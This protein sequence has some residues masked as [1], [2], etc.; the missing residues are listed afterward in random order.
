MSES[1]DEIIQAQQ[2]PLSH[3]S[4]ASSQRRLGNLLDWRSATV[5]VIVAVVLAS[6]LLW[7]PEL[8]APAAPSPASAETQS[9]TTNDPLSSNNTE[10]LAPFAEAQRQ[11]VREQAQEALAEFVEMQILLEDTMHVSEWGAAELAESLAIA[12]SGDTEFHAE[13]FEDSLNAYHNAANSLES[14]LARGNALFDQYVASGLEHI[15]SLDPDAATSALAEAQLIKP[16]DAALLAALQR[17][18]RLPQVIG[19]LRTAKNHELG[20]RYKK[21]LAQYAEIQQLDPLTAGLQQLKDAAARAQAGDDLTSHISRGFVALENREF[22]RAKQ[23]FNRA[24]ALDADNDIAKGGLQ[25][26]A[27]QN[28]L[29]II[30]RHKSAADSAMAAEDWQSAIDAFQAVLVL[31]AN[32]QFALNGLGAANAHQR[33]Q[34]LLDKISSEP[35]KL[36]S[37]KLYLDA[38]AIV[39]DAKK[40]EYAG[41]NLRGLVE[42]VDKLLLA[43]RD[44]V[45]VVLVSD[46]ATNV[47][48]SNVGQLGFFERKTLTLRPGQYTIRGSQDGCRDI[49]LLVEVLPGIAPLDLSCPES[50]SRN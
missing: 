42:T 35:Q 26:V 16:N 30:Q 28:D 10:R 1:R 9:T 2:A 40:L 19:M 34:R 49:F 36:S 48:M 46:N 41:Q 21:A 3:L 45:D 20:G 50:I 15:A 6:A 47:V 43:Y 14:I 32:I 17:T 25:Q 4:S 22:E 24:L 29:A 12:Q 5:A 11:R 23:A 31:D 37:E 44:P 39:D 7:Q 8:T 33:A 27:N 18:Q 13:H 38:V